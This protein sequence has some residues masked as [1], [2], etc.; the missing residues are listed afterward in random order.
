MNEPQ[1]FN[2]DKIQKSFQTKRTN[3]V[4]I[5]VQSD[6]TTGFYNTESSV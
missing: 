6:P 1:Y 2:I 4:Q 5:Q 3:C